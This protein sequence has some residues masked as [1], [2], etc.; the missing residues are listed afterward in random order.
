MRTST[1]DERKVR[2]DGERPSTG[3]NLADRHSD[4]MKVFV[5]LTFHQAQ[6]TAVDDLFHVVEVDTST[7]RTQP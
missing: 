6:I 3:S 2:E 7:D 1:L 4:A 5:L